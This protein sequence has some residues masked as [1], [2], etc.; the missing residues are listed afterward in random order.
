ML[1]PYNNSVAVGGVVLLFTNSNNDNVVVGV[2]FV[3]YNNDSVV[4]GV[5]LL[6][7]CPQ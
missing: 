4:G 5:V 6:F 7:S 1:V 3:P 2:V